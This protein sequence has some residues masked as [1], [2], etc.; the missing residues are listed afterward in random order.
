MKGNNYIANYCACFIDLLG[1]KDLYKDE[2]LFQELKTPEE[3]KIFSEK[4]HKSVGAI[5]TFQ[6]EAEN[7]LEKMFKEPEWLM[8]M[9]KDKQ[10]LCREL[11]LGKPKQ[12][13]W[14]DGLLYFVSLNSSKTKCPMNEIFTM[15]I[16]SSLSCFLG[17]AKGF[18]IRGAID[19]AWGTELHENELYGAVVAKAYELESKVAQYPRI[20]ISPQ[21]MNFIENHSRSSSED[22]LSRYSKKLSIMC[23]EI[24]EKDIDGHY[25]VNYLGKGF[26]RYVSKGQHSLLYKPAFEFVSKQLE[27]HKQN[28]N[29]KLAFRYSILRNYFERNNVVIKNE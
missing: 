27:K 10:Q 5:H 12:Q 29:T 26:Q 11:R 13:R 22:V 19:I 21:T 2:G 8:L 15:I 9:P 1:Q 28:Q 14:S 24:I 4:Y 6:K 18:P 17:L 7:F 3:K 20:V 16:F 25:I 23:L